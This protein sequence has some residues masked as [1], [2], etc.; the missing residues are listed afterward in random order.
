MIVYFFIQNFIKRDYGYYNAEYCWVWQR[1]NKFLT[2]ECAAFI[3]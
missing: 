2:D 1:T 3:N